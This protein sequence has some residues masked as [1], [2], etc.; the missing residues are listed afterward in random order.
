MVVANLMGQT[1]M[2]SNEK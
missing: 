1:F 2:F